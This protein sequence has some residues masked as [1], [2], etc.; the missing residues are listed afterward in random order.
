MQGVFPGYTDLI[1]TDDEQKSKLW[2][3]RTIN[4]L[5][6]RM[7]P[8]YEQLVDPSD[9]LSY[10][11][12]RTSEDRRWVSIWPEMEL[13]A[14]TLAYMGK[15]R[16]AIEELEIFKNKRIIE[17]DRIVDRIINELKSIPVGED[18]NFFAS[19]IAENKKRLG[20]KI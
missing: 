9:L 13:K 3:E 14:Y 17:N 12:N 19:V 15:K 11:E 8:F 16:R 7:I 20:L 10:I 5:N 18:D 2:A 1:E 4:I 6:N